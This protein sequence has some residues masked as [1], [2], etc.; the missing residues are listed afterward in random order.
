MATFSADR[1]TCLP[2]LGR[3]GATHPPC[4]VRVIVVTERLS[5]KG[6]DPLPGRVHFGHCVE[7]R[8]GL[9]PFRTA[10]EPQRTILVNCNLAGLAAGALSRAF[11]VAITNVGGSGS[12]AQGWERRGSLDRTD[13]TLSARASPAA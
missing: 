4:V 7:E 10:S 9:T 13:G 1:A 8:R 12:A 6:S 2:Q 3:I 5:E 11:T